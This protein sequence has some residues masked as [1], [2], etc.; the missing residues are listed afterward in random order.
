MTAT[1]L[2]VGAYVNLPVRAALKRAAAAGVLI[3]VGVELTGPDYGCGDVVETMRRD[4]R[5]L[6]IDAR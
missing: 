3:V 5:V 6:S 4:G 2:V 1:Y